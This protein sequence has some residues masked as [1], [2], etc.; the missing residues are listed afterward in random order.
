MILLLVL[1]APTPW[2][3][4]RGAS[5][6]AFFHVSR[7]T[8]E[9]TRYLSPDTV[10]ARL[11]IDTLHSVWDDP[12]PLEDR[13]RA[14]PQVADVSVSRKLPGTLVVKVRENPPVALVPGARGL[15][16]VDSTGR[17]LPIDPA[18]E[19][20]DLPISN[21]R[22]PGLI[23]MLGDVRAR[24]SVLYRRISEVSLDA[25]GDVVI[26]LT[27]NAP[28]SP[29]V[30][31]PSPPPTPSDSTVINRD[32]ATST[33]ASGPRML[34]VRARLGVSATRLTDIF[35]VE[36]HLRRR[37]ARV[38]ELDLRYREQVIARLQ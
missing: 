21:Q 1:L 30:P 7:V 24:H 32:T 2:L 16:A 38:A 35:P 36:F 18:R 23:R 31:V 11:A 12:A 13:V 34:R 17:S 37:G 29:P 15:E 25:S 26:L 5:K 20:L 14:L 8:V 27:S 22:D 28:E 3:A 10:V 9:G 19:A 4:R 33:A 6:L